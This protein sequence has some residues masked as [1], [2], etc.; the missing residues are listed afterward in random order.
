[1]S[2]RVERYIKKGTVVEIL[3]LSGIWRY[4]T[5]NEIYSGLFRSTLENN[6]L[7]NMQHRMI[8]IPAQKL[9]QKD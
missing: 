2:C 4:E 5:D 3:D 1:M 9:M 8:L 7:R 6:G